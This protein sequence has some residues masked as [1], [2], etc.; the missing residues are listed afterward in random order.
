[1]KRLIII[2]ILSTSAIFADDKENCDPTLPL[3]GQSIMDLAETKCLGDTLPRNDI[4][5]TLTKEKATKKFCKSCKNHLMSLTIDNR[6]QPYA[7]ATMNE[8]Q[9]ELTFISVDL[10]KMRSSFSMS[11]DSDIAVKSCN[12]KNLIPP[13]CLQ[14]KEIENFKSETVKIQNTMATELASLLSEKPILDEGFF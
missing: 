5:R 7:N 10:I 2:F 3:S 14:G 12:F 11:F 1:M 6:I 9:K 13:T 8:L 4:S